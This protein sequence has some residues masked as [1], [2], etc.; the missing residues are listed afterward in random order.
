MNGSASIGPN[1]QI[2]VRIY[3]T[4]LLWTVDGSTLEQTQAQTFAFRRLNFPHLFTVF[5]LIL[6]FFLFSPS[7]GDLPFLLFTL[8]GK[9]VSWKCLVEPHKEVTVDLRRIEMIILH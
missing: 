4:E 3:S 1:W 9:N 5:L 6:L 7:V 8:T 2:G